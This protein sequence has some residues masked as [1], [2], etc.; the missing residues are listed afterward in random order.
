[1]LA[2][3]QQQ[4]RLR[5]APRRV[6]TTSEPLTES[7]RRE[8]EET[9]DVPVANGYAATEAPLMA[10]SA[11]EHDDLLINEDVVVLEIVDENDRPVPP[12]TPGAKVLLTNLVNRAL[13]LI[14]Y[15]LSDT[16]TPAGDEPPLPYP[17]RRVS[18]VDG[19]SVDV[20]YLPREGGGQV[21]VH[22]FRLGTCFGRLHDVRQFQVVHHERGIT[23]RLV[24][25][26]DAAPD[27]A[28]QV[29]NAVS[30]ELVEAGAAPPVV[31]VDLVDALEREPGP[32]AK[33]KLVQST[34]PRRAG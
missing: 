8:I 26:P 28:A 19:R 34:V 13:P 21:A 4:G 7:V 25:R 11:A 27:V 16:V 32:A 15:E 33:L 24:A 9:W 12:G 22:P 23:V 31:D 30:A 18:R 29:R 1:M 10:S 6:I 2:H 3:E 14:R 5:I 17:Y 20:L